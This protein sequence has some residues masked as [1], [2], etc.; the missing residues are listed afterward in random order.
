[1]GSLAHHIP[2]FL[3]YDSSKQ[4]NSEFLTG[5]TFLQIEWLLAYAPMTIGSHRH[6][7]YS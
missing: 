1:M 6:L 2:Q 5:D 4:S 3:G 7:N